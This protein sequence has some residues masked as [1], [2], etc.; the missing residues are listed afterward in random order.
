MKK[1]NLEFKQKIVTQV[2]KRKISKTEAAET[3]GCKVQTIYRLL[4]KVRSLGQ[5]S[6]RSLSTF[7]KKET[8]TGVS[9]AFNNHC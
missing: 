8:S 7:R 6:C 3:L 9:S 5:N 4:E 1:H 2:L